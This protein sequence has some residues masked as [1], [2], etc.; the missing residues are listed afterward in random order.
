MSETAQSIHQEV[1][2]TKYCHDPL[3]PASEFASA[4]LPTTTVPDSKYIPLAEHG[5]RRAMNSRGTIENHERGILGE[6]AVAD[7]FGVSDVVDTSLYENGDP[8]F[9]LQMGPWTI[10]VKTAGPCFDQP[11]LM[12]NATKNLSADFYVLTQQLSQQ[13]YRIIGYAPSSRVA[14][15]PVRQI[16]PH[17]ADEVYVLDQYKLN[18]LH[19]S[20][21]DIFAP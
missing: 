17:P 10:D 1:S 15:A 7:F 20:A 2:G 14:M 21:S 19:A 18:P 16:G 6:Y 11:S 13:H 4:L 5:A 9:D 8:G 3:V 12:V